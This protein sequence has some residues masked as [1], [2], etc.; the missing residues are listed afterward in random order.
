MTP[1][2]TIETPYGPKWQCPGCTRWWFSPPG[3]PH[4]CHPPGPPAP[5]PDP[6]HAARV[7]R[8]NGIGNLV[9][10]VVGVGILAGVLWH[11]PGLWHDFERWN[12]RVTACLET[13]PESRTLGDVVRSQGECSRA[14]H[15][16]VTP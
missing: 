6:A 1:V 14:A 5:E 16:E 10:V 11:L 4:A 7:A 12:T 15:A 2:G 13:A 3:T 8:I 9:A